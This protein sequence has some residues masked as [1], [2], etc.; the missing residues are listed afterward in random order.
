MVGVDLSG[1]APLRLLLPLLAAYRRAWPAARLVVKNE[2]L[3]CAVEAA[4]AG[5]AA[6]PAAAAPAADALP[7]AA[8]AEAVAAADTAAAA[9]A[10]QRSGA[11]GPDALADELEACRLPSCSSSSS[12]PGSG[13][14]STRSSSISAS[15]RAPDPGTRRL[16]A[17]L[18]PDCELF[19]NEG[20]LSHPDKQWNKVKDRT[21]R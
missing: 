15:S 2:A 11:S 18:L 8:G 14:V 10:V 16:L 20:F 19:C 17:E 4:Q 3:Y 5:A 12:A 21:C 1:K 6:A 7:A 9:Q 13:S